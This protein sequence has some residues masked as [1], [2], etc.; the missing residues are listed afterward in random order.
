MSDTYEQQPQA[1]PY[2]AAP[3][4][5]AGGLAATQT[6][7]TG[8]MPQLTPVGRLILGGLLDAVLMVVTLWIGW[9]IWAAIT[10]AEG[11]TPAKKLLGMR[12]V[13]VNTGRPLSWGQYVFMRGL[14]GGMVLSFAATFTLGVLYFMP[15]W[16]KRNQSIAAKVSNSVVVDV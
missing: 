16:D 14:L 4:P 9:T 8:A 1:Q 6:P 5:Q 12:V 13:D 3:V 7:L 10:A 15:L 11:Q 2:A